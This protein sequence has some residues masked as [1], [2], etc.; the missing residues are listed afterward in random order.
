MQMNANSNKPAKR[1]RG[2]ILHERRVLL[3]EVELEKN[4]FDKK[5]FFLDL[6]RSITM[7]KYRLRRQTQ[8]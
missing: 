2:D 4:S 8:L 6:T 5:K 1:T 7:T 3:G